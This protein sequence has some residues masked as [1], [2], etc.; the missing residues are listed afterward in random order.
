MVGPDSDRNA[1]IASDVRNARLYTRTVF[2]PGSTC[3]ELKRVE[4][5]RVTLISRS[6][7]NVVG[8]HDDSYVH[9]DRKGYTVVRRRSTANQPRTSAQFVLQYDPPSITK[10]TRTAIPVVAATPRFSLKNQSARP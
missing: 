4:L 1:E 2:T 7:P 10:I 6:H 9:Q 3:M 8:T 5:R